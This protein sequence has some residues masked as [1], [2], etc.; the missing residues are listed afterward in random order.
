MCRPGA[1][2]QHLK[3][4][5]GE[6]RQRLPSARRAKMTPDCLDLFAY[7]QCLSRLVAQD[8]VLPS[9]N[10]PASLDCAYMSSWT[11]LTMPSGCAFCIAVPDSPYAQWNSS[12]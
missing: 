12:F 3:C 8:L 5:P 9:S 6:A 10:P 4:L 1:P 11:A 2:L 7:A